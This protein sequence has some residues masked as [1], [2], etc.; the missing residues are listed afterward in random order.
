MIK[1]KQSLITDDTEHAKDC[2]WNKIS[3]LKILKLTK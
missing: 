2:I 1:Q 3:Y